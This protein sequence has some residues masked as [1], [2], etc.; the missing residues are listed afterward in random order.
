LVCSSEHVGDRAPPQNR[1]PEGGRRVRQY[2]TQPPAPPRHPCPPRRRRQ[3]MRPSAPRHPPR[4][5]T[6]S[7]PF[8]CAPTCSNLFQRVPTC[9][10]GP[11]AGAKRSHSPRPL[12]TLASPRP[13]PRPPSRLGR[14]CHKPIP[15]CSKSFQCAPSHTRAQNEPNLRASAIPPPS[16]LPLET[17]PPPH[18]R[19]APR[20]PPLA[21][22][23][24]PRRHR[25][26][27][28]RHHPHVRPLEAPPGLPS[29]APPPAGPPH[30]RQLN[31]CVTPW[32]IHPS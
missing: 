7:N 26:D 18:S 23:P 32:Y 30:Q 19:P 14:P 24:L 16:I 17:P 3:R 27:S 4:A 9:T 8:Q 2:P 12:R 21:R 5:P 31:R 11:L 28:R 10:I 6:C 20:R 1:Q 25:P 15:T 29:R 13:N 22:R